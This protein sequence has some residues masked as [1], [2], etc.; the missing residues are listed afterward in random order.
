MLIIAQLWAGT[1]AKFLR[2]LT[3]EE[4]ASIP[5]L[6]EEIYE[7]GQQHMAEHQKDWEDVAREMEFD[8]NR[9]QILSEY[10][11]APSK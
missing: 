6:A 5:K 9:E 4:I 11:Y 1:P 10:D 3:E 2:K 8:K 7:L